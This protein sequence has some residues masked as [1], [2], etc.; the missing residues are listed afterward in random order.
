MRVQIT[1]RA[2]WLQIVEDRLKAIEAE[3]AQRTRQFFDDRRQGSFSW[4][5]KQLGKP[6]RVLTDEQIE[7]DMDFGESLD[8][9]NVR[10]FKEASYTTLRLLR[11]ALLSQAT[12]DIYL[13]AD[14][15]RAVRL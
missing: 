3:R 10:Y 5:R 11:V 2:H 14:D 12:G 4:L 15:L 6:S 13:E 8:L 1:D 7:A 9:H